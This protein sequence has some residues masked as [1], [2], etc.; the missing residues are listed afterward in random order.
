MFMILQA[1]ILSS[2][3]FL[4]ILVLNLDKFERTVFGD[5]PYDHKSLKNPSTAFVSKELLLCNG[6]SDEVKE[7]AKINSVKI[8]LNI[9]SHLLSYFRLIDRRV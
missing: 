8:L 2:E 7:S 3:A 9:L 1:C 5:S 4:H 6:H